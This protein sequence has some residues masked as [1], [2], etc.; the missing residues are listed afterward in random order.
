MRIVRDKDGERFLE[1]KNKNDFEKFKRDLLK[2]V[3][4]KSVRKM[5]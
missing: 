4:E 5:S 1:I 2:R 3:R